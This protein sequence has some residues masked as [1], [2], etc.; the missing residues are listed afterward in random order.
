MAVQDRDHVR[1]S[2]EAALETLD[3]LRRERNFRDENDRGLAAREGGADRLQINLRLAAAGDAVKQD[4]RMRR[5]IIQR[6]L[7]SAARRR[8]A[9]SSTSD[10][11]SA[12]NFSVPCGSRAI[13]CSRSSTKPR[14]TSARRVGLS[15]EVWRRRSAAGIGRRQVSRCVEQLRL[16]RRALAQFLDFL[17]RSGGESD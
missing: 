1:L 3:R 5:R 6:G 7:R 12:M 11:A 14:F 10:S 13:A 9:R 8:S 2:G 17:R 15:S 16:A 4:R